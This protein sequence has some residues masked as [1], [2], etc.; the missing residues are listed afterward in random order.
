MRLVTPEISKAEWASPGILKMTSV[1]LVLRRPLQKGQS[2]VATRE[3]LEGQDTLG[4][5]LKKASA[6][7]QVQIGEGSLSGLPQASH[8]E[9]S[10]LSISRFKA[11]PFFLLGDFS[12]NGEAG[13]Q[14]QSLFLACR[15][16]QVQ[17]LGLSSCKMSEVK[18]FSALAPT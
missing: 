16:T 6:V 9:R 8:P 7:C 18:C 5:P 1:M 3:D 12:C 2:Q 10:E 14:R 11:W 13:A 4:R 15:R 17:V